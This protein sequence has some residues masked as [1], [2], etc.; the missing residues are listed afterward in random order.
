MKGARAARG[1]EWVDR[2]VRSGC[3]KVLSVGL[4]WGRHHD[5]T[6]W[7]ESEGTLALLW[8]WSTYYTLYSCKDNS[9]DMTWSIGTSHTHVHL[10]VWVPLQTNIASSHCMYPAFYSCTHAL[11][12]YPPL[13]FQCS[14]S[15]FPLHSNLWY[16]SHALCIQVLNAFLTSVLSYNFWMKSIPLWLLVDFIPFCV[17]YYGHISSTKSK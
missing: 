9:N 16:W 7:K 4:N 1:A 12:T 3:L 10:C 14:F 8:R 13:H 11:V 5:R 15:N 17:A 2:R 6:H